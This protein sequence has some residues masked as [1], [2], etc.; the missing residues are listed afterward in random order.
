MYF[1]S[2]RTLR[3]PAQQQSRKANRRDGRRADTYVKM[4]RNQQQHQ[5]EGH[6]FPV[7]HMITTTPSPCRGVERFMICV[8]GVVWLDLASLGC[9]DNINENNGSLEPVNLTHFNGKFSSGYSNRLLCQQHVF[10]GWTIIN[11][12]VRMFPGC[13]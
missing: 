1:F 12:L 8:R 5:T 10:V 4:F 2:E 7:S 6:V 9:Q 3:T 11:R 13:L